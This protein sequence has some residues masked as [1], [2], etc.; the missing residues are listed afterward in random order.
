[1]RRKSYHF[2]KYLSL[3]VAEEME[4]GEKKAALWGVMRG[5]QSAAMGAHILA[6]CTKSCVYSYD[7][8][9][10][11][12]SEESCAR[13][14]MLKSFDFEDYVNQELRYALRGLGDWGS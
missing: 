3:E 11:R 6:K 2:Y 12:P 1:M 13:N 5:Y 8:A 4:D 7:E 10:L 14:C 9:E